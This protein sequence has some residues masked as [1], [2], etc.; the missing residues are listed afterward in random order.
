[1]LPRALMLKTSGPP[2]KLG[3]FHPPGLYAGLAVEME[4]FLQTKTLWSWVHEDP[5]APTTDP[6]KP[7]AS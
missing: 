1:M 5:P 4:P 3:C 2:D 6:D 7:K